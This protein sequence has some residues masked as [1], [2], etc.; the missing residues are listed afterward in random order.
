MSSADNRFRFTLD[1]RD[2][3]DRGAL[4]E[5]IAMFTGGL[6]VGQR[7]ISR[8]ATYHIKAARTHFEIEGGS[9][10]AL[11]GESSH[12]L[13][14]SHFCLMV[15]FHTSNIGVHFDGT[16]KDQLPGC[17]YLPGVAARPI[18]FAKPFQDHLPKKKRS[19]AIAPSALAAVHEAFSQIP[20]ST[21]RERQIT[22]DFGL[23]VDRERSNE[24]PHHGHRVSG[25]APALV[26]ED[27]VTL[28][29]QTRP[30]RTWGEAWVAHDE[31]QKSI[32]GSLAILPNEVAFLTDHL[33]RYTVADRG[34]LK[35]L[36]TITFGRGKSRVF[37]RDDFLRFADRYRTLDNKAAAY[38]CWRQAAR[39]S[40]SKAQKEEI[41][42][43]KADFERERKRLTLPDGANRPVVRK[44]FSALV[45]TLGETGLSEAVHI[46]D[47]CDAAWYHSDFGRY[48]DRMQV[49]GTTQHKLSAEQLIA[50]GF[51]RKSLTLV[52][53]R[54]PG[55]TVSNKPETALILI[56]IGGHKLWGTIGSGWFALDG[57]FNTVYGPIPPVT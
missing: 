16:E 19:P 54:D 5:A 47:E 43:L 27:G 46:A 12:R 50:A 23:R 17:G 1:R 15:A 26:L 6:V 42:R 9:N 21:A 10:A 56:S 57:E 11:G 20:T 38:A 44:S 24:D 22:V 30:A 55:E 33:F 29:L 25:Y 52:L 28:D 53:G 14:A 51:S 37:D 13:M 7:V 32:L 4:L 45:E 41:D 49:A 8:V 36:S 31:P 35:R 3:L 18:A 34:T 39:L 48:R 2:E 40:A